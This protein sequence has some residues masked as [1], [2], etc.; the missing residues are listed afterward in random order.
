MKYETIIIWYT[1]EKEVYEYDTRE[2]AEKA[3][4]GYRMAFGNQIQW[5]GTRVK[6]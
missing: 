1:G 2:E 6:R 3:A 5:A 4:E